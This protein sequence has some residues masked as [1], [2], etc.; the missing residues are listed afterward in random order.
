[1]KNIE[2]ATTEFSLAKTL[3]C[4]QYF[5]YM[6]HPDGSFTGIIYDKVV[7]LK[8][9]NKILLAEGEVSKK[10]LSSFFTLDVDYLAINNEISS[11]DTLRKILEF[12]SGIHIL[13]QPLF[14][15]LITFI[16]S[17]NNNI[18]R[19][20]TIVNSLCRLFGEEIS[21]GFYSF[22]KPEVLASLNL[23]DLSPL[24]CGFRDKYILDAA[25]RWVSGDIN[26][27][28]VGKAPSDIARSELMKIKGVGPKVAN[29]T[30][31]YGAARFDILPEDVWIK[32]ALAEYFPDGLPEFVLEY[33]GIIQQYIFY[34][35]RNHL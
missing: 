34:Y 28:I 20:T 31:L 21:S 10:T 3:E 5:R 15:S 18:K 4:G 8:Q 14:E 16:I 32:R 30:L 7:Y 9:D 2:I 13:R 25:T 17:Q 29:C 27:D 12:S 6:K 1:M 23:S 11:N 19:I 24:R 26:Q 33:A 35:A 22:P